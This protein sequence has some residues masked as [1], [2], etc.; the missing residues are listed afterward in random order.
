MGFWD[1]YPVNTG[2]TAGVG[3]T[4]TNAGLANRQTLNA[5]INEGLNY[6]SSSRQAPQA[7]GV[8]MNTGPQAQARAMEMEQARRLA[9]IASGNQKGAG[10]MGVDRQIGAALA[11]QQA[12]A[13]MSRGSTAGVGGLAA[14]RGSQQIGV[15]GAG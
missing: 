10:E 13:R 7:G 1:Y 4:E 11:N 14:A 15:S 8:Q 2:G 6:G 9:A 12:Q 3:A 5:Y